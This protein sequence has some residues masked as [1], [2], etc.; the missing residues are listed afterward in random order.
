[1]R[2][3]F[4]TCKPF[5]KTQVLKPLKLHFLRERCRGDLQEL[6][7]L[8][9]RLQD[10][11]NTQIRKFDSTHAVHLSDAKRN[12]FVKAGK[13]SPDGSGPY[14]D[15]VTLKVDPASSVFTTPGGTIVNI[16]TLDLRD[17]ELQ[18]TVHIRDV[19]Y[20][21]DTY[22]PRLFVDHC[23]L[24]EI[25]QEDQAGDGTSTKT[26]PDSDDSENEEVTDLVESDSENMSDAE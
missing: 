21:G 23:V 26:G 2:T 3:R 20:L 10:Q 18:P 25:P 19:W 1:M 11:V 8:L 9:T 6:R 5:D 7:V 14:P 15:F 17:Y 24:H 22:Y 16:S 12:V 4:E 13:P